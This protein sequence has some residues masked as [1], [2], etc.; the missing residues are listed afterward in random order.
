M[1]HQKKK[2]A[3][4]KFTKGSTHTFKIVGKDIGDVKSINI[5]V[6]HGF[7]FSQHNQQLFH[8]CITH[9][10]L[11]AVVIV[12]IS[13]LFTDLI[14]MMPSHSLSSFCQCHVSKS[15][16]FRPSEIQLGFNGSLNTIHYFAPKTICYTLFFS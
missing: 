16:P 15:L 8:S 11:V 13:F 1:G 14:T 4:F 12:Q 7:C 9:N 2:K 3:H 6:R 5:E 10:I